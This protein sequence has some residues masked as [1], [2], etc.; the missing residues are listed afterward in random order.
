MKILT[1]FIWDGESGG[2]D[3]YLMSFARVASSQGV[4]LDFLTNEYCDGLVENL[5]SMGHGLYEIATL[6][7][8][9]KQRNLIFKLHEE[10]CYALLHNFNILYGPYVPG[11]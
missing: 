6:R 11:W 8:R 10:N 7:E 9:N 2:I 1:G 4:K 5:A 3:R